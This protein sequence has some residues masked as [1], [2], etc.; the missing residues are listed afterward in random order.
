MA[1]GEAETTPG[2]PL[3]RGWLAAA[4]LAAAY[5][6]LMVVGR[7]YSII[8]DHSWGRIPWSLINVGLFAWAA[9]TAWRYARSD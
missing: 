8:V 3:H 7:S 6:G 5:A 4:I 9:V 2:P 1:T